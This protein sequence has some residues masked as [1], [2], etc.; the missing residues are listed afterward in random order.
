MDHDEKVA[1]LNDEF[2]T[3]LGM[4]VL[5]GTVL[6]SPGLERL[7]AHA[8]ANILLQIVGYN[9]IAQGNLSEWRRLGAF[10]TEYGEIGWRIWC[11][12]D[13]SRSHEVDG[14][15]RNHY[16]VM[17]VALVSELTG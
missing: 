6:I 15:E 3:A 9:F 16:R 11:Y 8:V 2:R 7:G 5:P 14:S 10:E 17:R 13:G 12:A 1:R 4:G